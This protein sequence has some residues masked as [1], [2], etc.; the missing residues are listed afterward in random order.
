VQDEE[1]PEVRRP[2]KKIFMV[3]SVEKSEPGIRGESG[4]PR[5]FINSGIFYAIF[6]V[7]P[8]VTQGDLSCD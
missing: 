6:M 4:R 7:I 3:N 5:I 2:A 8:G 1:D